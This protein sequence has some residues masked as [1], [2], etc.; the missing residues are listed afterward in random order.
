MAVF[1]FSYFFKK[2]ARNFATSLILSVPLSC[3][4]QLIQLV[5]LPLTSLQATLLRQICTS[6]NNPLKFQSHISHGIWFGSS[7]T[8]KEESIVDL[9][10]EDPRICIFLCSVIW[11]K[12]VHI[13]LK[14]KVD[15]WKTKISLTS[16]SNFSSFSISWLH[17]TVALIN[18]GFPQ[19]VEV[20]T[21]HFS[22]YMWKRHC[23]RIEQNS[24]KNRLK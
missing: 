17:T 7:L 2:K 13:T 4:H 5:L 19:R 1:L 6:S 24:L 12:E 21:I 11:W 20:G 10:L 23:L 9:W 14:S 16:I 15:K 3:K 18:T 8:W 22:S